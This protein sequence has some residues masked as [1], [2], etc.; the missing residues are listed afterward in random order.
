MAATVMTKRKPPYTLSSESGTP[1][2][3]KRSL[4]NRKISFLFEKNQLGNLEQRPSS[5]NYDSLLSWSDIEH[6]ELQVKKYINMLKE[7][8]VI[9]YSN[10]F[11]YYRDLEA[12]F[13]VFGT[14]QQQEKYLEYET[15]RG[16]QK[17]FHCGEVG[18]WKAACTLTCNNKKCEKAACNCAWRRGHF[19]KRHGT[20]YVGKTFLQIAVNHP[21]YFRWVMRQ[22]EPALDIYDLQE[23]GKNC[24]VLYK[25]VADFWIDTEDTYLTVPNEF[26]PCPNLPSTI[27]V[28]KRNRYNEIFNIKLGEEIEIENNKFAAIK[29]HESYEKN[30]T[31][32]IEEYLDKEEDDKNKMKERTKNN[33]EQTLVVVTSATRCKIQEEK[34][35]ELD[36]ESPLY[37]NETM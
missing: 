28:A 14:V 7:Q 31:I 3:V 24:N 30:H 33:E 2:K 9:Q 8:Q 29:K 1:K 36:R 32:T 10:N 21:S 20:K 37:C 35:F 17:C 16:P 23:W 22:W 15:L 26:V 18:H 25:K 4:L 13:G 5:P 11:V 34:E 19:I 6:I 12:M 27:S